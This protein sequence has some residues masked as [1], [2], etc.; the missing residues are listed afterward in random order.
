MKHKLILLLFTVPLFF[1]QSCQIDTGLAPTQSGIAGVVHFQ[2][3]WPETTDEVMVVASTKFPPTSLEEIIMSE[4][5]PTFV[6]SASFVIWTNPQTF[7][8]VGVVW[9]EKGQPWDVTNII[10]I[11]FPTSDH[12]SPGMVTIPDRNTLVDSISIDANLANA[13]LRVD[14][15]I[16]G[17]LR[18]KGD[19]PDGAE[20]VL[21]I[22]SKT[23]LPTSLLDI[24]FGAPIVAGFDSTA[25]SLSLQPGTYRLIGSL[26]TETGKSIGVESIKGIYRKNPGDFLPG[27]VVV[28][29]DTTV[30]ENIDITLNFES[31]LLP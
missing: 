9:K 23:V 4:P 8:A 17:M 13:R 11:Y 19:W 31:G 12:F 15:A 10:G 3:E 7:Q 20:S 30:A 28:P 21:V 22:A 18:V 27:S 14:S 29:T 5:L 24:V 26:V 25:Y 16:K 1:L 6:D 2:N